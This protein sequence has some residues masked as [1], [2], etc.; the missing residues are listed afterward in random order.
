MIKAEVNQ[1]ILSGAHRLST[2]TL[3]KI[4][5]LVS[6]KTQPHKD[7]Q[8]SLAFVSPA[9]IKILN[10][11]YRGQNRVTD[12]LSFAFQKASSA[13]ADQLLGEI[14]ICYPQAKKNAQ[15][16]GLPVQQEINRLI[17]HGLLHL[18][19]FQHHTAKKAEQMFKLQEQIL[20]QIV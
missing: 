5:R 16:D 4:L 13:Q 1:N 7:F 12:V 6:Q 3:A 17:I 11:D 8:V 18:F 14:L 15:A 9:R 2:R 19:G 10:R 20:N